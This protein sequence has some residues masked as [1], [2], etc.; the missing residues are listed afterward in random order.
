M[1]M[2]RGKE[3]PALR[4]HLCVKR[5]QRKQGARSCIRAGARPPRRENKERRSGG[6]GVE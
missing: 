1:L 4:A 3:D 6:G 5:P 2:R